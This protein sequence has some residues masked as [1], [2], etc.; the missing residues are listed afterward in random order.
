MFLVSKVY[1]Y[2]QVDVNYVG[3][4]LYNLDNIV[5][6]GWFCYF[7]FVIIDGMYIFFSCSLYQDLL[8]WL[9][10]VIVK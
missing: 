1:I 2:V 4:M 6:L 7:N 10:F 3:F 8:L 9:C 5:C